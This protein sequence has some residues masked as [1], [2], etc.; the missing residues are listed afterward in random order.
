MLKVRQTRGNGTGG[1]KRKNMRRATRSEAEEA[2]Q[3]SLQPNKHSHDDD[4]CALRPPVLVLARC[5]AYIC[6]LAPKLRG[7]AEAHEND[8]TD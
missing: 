2:S 1:R 7:A 8:N 6:Q 3:K 5:H 4:V